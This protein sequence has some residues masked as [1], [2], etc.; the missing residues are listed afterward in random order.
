M[1]MPLQSYK[2]FQVCDLKLQALHTCWVCL[3]GHQSRCGE[4]CAALGGHACSG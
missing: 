4:M 1:E 2:T 3:H